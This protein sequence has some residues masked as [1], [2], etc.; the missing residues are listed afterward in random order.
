MPRNSALDSV[1]GMLDDLKSKLGFSRGENDYGNYDD[2]DEYSEYGDNYDENAPVGGFRPATS[3]TPRSS[4][5]NRNDISTSLVSIEDVKAS[6]PLPDRLNRDPLARPARPVSQVTPPT[7]VAP[8]SFAP[9]ASAASGASAIPETSAFA[10][11]SGAY[12]PYEAFSSPNPS[13]HSPVRKLTVVKP[14][15]YGDVELVSRAVKSGDVVVLAM[16]NTPDDLSKRIL[17]FSFGVASALDASVECP[18]EKVFAIARGA[19]LS[20]S[21]KLNLSSQGVL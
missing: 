14:V 21:E 10:Q 8:A 19:G 4:R 18:A 16:R 3:Y 2:F 20:D 15:D 6:T 11:Q 13:A 12:D 5:F 17:D 1:G 7:T 9:V